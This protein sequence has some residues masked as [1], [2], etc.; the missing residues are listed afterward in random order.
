M[1]YSKWTYS[2]R[3]KDRWGM[4]HG[5]RRGQADIPKVVLVVFREQ[6]GPSFFLANRK[7]DKE[8][9]LSQRRSHGCF[10][11]SDE[12]VEVNIVLFGRCINTSFERPDFPSLGNL[13][14]RKWQRNA[15]PDV[16][17]EF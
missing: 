3:Q 5:R 11:R 4:S 16:R 1:K 6:R 15:T 13:G 7:D 8:V 17:C 10:I 9:I 14:N 12:A 2:A